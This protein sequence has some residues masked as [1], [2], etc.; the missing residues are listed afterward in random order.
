VFFFRKMFYR[1]SFTH[2]KNTFTAIKNQTS[3]YCFW[4]FFIRFLLVIFIF[5]IIEFNLNK[6]VVVV[7]VVLERGLICSL[8]FGL[9]TFTQERRI[10]TIQ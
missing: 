8:A 6:N 7:V 5:F 3:R 9:T 1:N 4:F 10:Y 2:R